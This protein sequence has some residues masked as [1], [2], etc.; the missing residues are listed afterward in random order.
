[1]KSRIRDAEKMKIPY[2]VVV[3]DKEIETETVSI[4]AR[5]NREEGLMKTQE[6]IDNLKEEIRNKESFSNQNS[7]K[8][9]K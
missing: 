2:I 1:M 9:H 8:N 6:F 5:N 4:R 7:N 3:G